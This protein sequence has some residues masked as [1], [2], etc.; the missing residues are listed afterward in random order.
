[1]KKNGF[2]VV[3]TGLSLIAGT[4]SLL[5]DQNDGAPAQKPP[6][7]ANLQGLTNTEG[8]L[9][10]VRPIITLTNAAGPVAGLGTNVPSDEARKRA[11]ALRAKGGMVRPM[12]PEE[13]RAKLQTR[14]DDLRRKKAQGTITP[15]EEKQLENMENFS[16]RLANQESLAHATTNAVPG[17]APAPPE[18]PK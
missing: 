6:P 8:Q 12:S 11:E 15:I 1:M 14:L 17:K 3:L 7:T 10:P 4:P 16:K 13:R 9:Q 18:P 2:L 5:A